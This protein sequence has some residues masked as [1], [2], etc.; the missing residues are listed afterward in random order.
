MKLILCD[1]TPFTENWTAVYWKN[2]LLNSSAQT[3]PMAIMTPRFIFFIKAVAKE[4]LLLKLTF[5]SNGT[6]FKIIIPL[7]VS[8][9]G[10]PEWKALH[11]SKKRRASIHSTCKFELSSIIF[12]AK[13]AITKMRDARRAIRDG[14]HVAHCVMYFPHQ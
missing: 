14:L 4:C 5:W 3:P 11:Y 2:S 10:V 7:F 12:S 9:W 8:R 13:G 6:A 1:V